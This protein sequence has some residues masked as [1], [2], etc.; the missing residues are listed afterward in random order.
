MLI[1]YSKKEKKMETKLGNMYE[2][3]L[4]IYYF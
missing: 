1:V 4:L 2:K 3:N